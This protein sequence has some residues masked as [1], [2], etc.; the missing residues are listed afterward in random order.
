MRLATIFLTFSNQ[1]GFGL[2][3]VE[4]MACGCLVVGYHGHGGKEF[5]KPEWSFRLSRVM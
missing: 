3:P 1:E 4:A 5:L 2:P